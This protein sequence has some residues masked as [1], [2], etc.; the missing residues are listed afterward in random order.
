MNI[1]VRRNMIEQFWEMCLETN[2]NNWYPIM[3]HQT[4]DFMETMNPEIIKIDARHL[5]GSVVD[6]YSI[7]MVPP[8]R[9]IENIHG[10]Y[11]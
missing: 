11:H 6:D 8:L 5:W 3:N 2:R 7:L 9:Q 10:F 1:Y 4:M